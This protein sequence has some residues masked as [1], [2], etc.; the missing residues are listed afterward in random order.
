MQED[1]A[2]SHKH[3]AQQRRFDF[4]N[5][6]KLLW[7]GNSP[8]LNAIEP[9]WPYMKRRTTCRGAKSVGKRMRKQWIDKWRKMPQRRI[10]K[11]IERIPRHIQK[12]LE[13]EINGRNNYKEG[14]E[15]FDT[16]KGQ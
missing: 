10:Q 3:K 8:D 15:D 14:R 2:P 13:P 16:R 6:Q 11:W 4:W 7:P 5:M 12:I 9:A 1:G